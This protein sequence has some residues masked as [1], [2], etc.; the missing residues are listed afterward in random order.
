MV[1]YCT[2]ISLIFLSVLALPNPTLISGLSSSSSSS[3]GSSRK[4]LDC[5]DFDKKNESFHEDLN[6]SNFQILLTHRSKGYESSHGQSNTERD[7]YLV[8]NPRFVIDSCTI[9]DRTR[10]P[11]KSRINLFERGTRRKREASELVRTTNS[12]IRR[13][14]QSKVELTERQKFLKDKSSR[15]RRTAREEIKSSKAEIK[16]L[17]KHYYQFHDSRIAADGAKI[18]RGN[19][20]RDAWAD[21]YIELETVKSNIRRH[22]RSGNYLQHI[23][24]IH[25]ALHEQANKMKDIPNRLEKE[26]SDLKSKGRVDTNQ[27]WEHSLEESQK[28]WKFRDEVDQHKDLIRFNKKSLRKLEK[29]KV[30]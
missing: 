3:D 26:M 11:D 21:K 22:E 15:I 5:S 4:E 18:Q 24:A 13:P 25:Q 14:E 6:E 9:W 7:V 30:Q 16:K 23:P 19:T 10:I 8:I 29:H 28:Y 2:F 17:K 12:P 20:I 27:Y 1:A